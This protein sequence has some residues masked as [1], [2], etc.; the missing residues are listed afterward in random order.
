MRASKL[1]T[2]LPHVTMHPPASAQAIADFVA[3]CGTVPHRDYL[4]FMATH[5]GCDGPV[6]QEFYLRIWP[7]EIALARTEA[8]CTAEFAPGLLLFA[9][10]GG[11]TV[12][13]FD[14][15]D[16]RWPIVEVSM[17]ALSRTEMTVV[18]QSFTEFLKKAAA[19]EL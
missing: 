6:G 9:G 12:Y 8:C 1:E 4:E 15:Q 5:N 10:D 2:L 19:A 16:P 18:A 13:A 17:S 3:R 11:D 14:R 7:M